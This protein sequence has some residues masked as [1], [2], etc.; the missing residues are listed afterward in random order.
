MPSPEEH[1]A[2]YIKMRDECTRIRK[3]ADEKIADLKYKMS[4]IEHGFTNHVF[5]NGMKSMA[6]DAGRAHVETRRKFFVK[7][8]GDFTDFILASPSDRLP[9][10]EL[11]PLQRNC[12]DYVEEHDDCPDG[13][14][15][16]SERKVIIT[17]TS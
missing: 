8:R 6:T 15:V 7:D 3:V 5:N 16:L 17:R 1:I 13:I 12:K 11:R 9:L 14:D 2:N 10:L 4:R